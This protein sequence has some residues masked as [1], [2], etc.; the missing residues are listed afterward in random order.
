MSFLVNFLSDDGDSDMEY[1][2]EELKRH[3]KNY[4]KKNLLYDSSE[5]NVSIVVFVL[6]FS[7]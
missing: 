3:H 1:Y 5:L 4:K 6:N 7:Q 2:T